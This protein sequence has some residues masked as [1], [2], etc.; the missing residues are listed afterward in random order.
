VRLAA[1]R[2]FTSNFKMEKQNGNLEGST[3]EPVN[4]GDEMTEAA[5]GATTDHPRV[6]FGS[7]E[8]RLSFRQWVV[9]GLILVA[10]FWSVPA[11]WKVVEKFQ[12]GPGY[13]IPYALSRD[14]WLYE[15]WIGKNIQPNKVIILGDSVVWG[16]YVD[17]QGSYGVFLTKK[18][19]RGQEFINGGVNGLFPLAMEGMVDHYLKLPKGQKIVVH[20]NLL[21]LTSPEADLSTKKEEHFNHA[22]LVPQFFPK[23]PCYRAD[24]NERL[25]ASLQNRVGFLGWTNHLQDAYFEQ[26]SILNWTLADNGAEP[27]AY[28]NA[29]R[30][31][32]GQITMSVPLAPN[33]DPLRGVGSDRHHPWS[34]T[35]VGTTRFDWVELRESMQWGAFRRVLEVLRGRGNEV[36]VVVGPLNEHLMDAENRI[37]YVAIRDGVGEWLSGAKVAHCVL[38][39]LPSLLYADASHPLTSGYELMAE[40][41]M[42]D[43]AFKKWL[44]RP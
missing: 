39:A 34:T 37:K 16:E 41:T 22:R 5:V 33:P 12:V 35:G 24:A 44:A 27:P 38:E 9:T 28:L 8:V 36:F 13:R 42:A 20:C 14:Y 4:R 17:P 7:N 19:D 32:L 31:P 43:E 29:W 23:I 6:P 10:I 30:N 21:W 3:E 15:R 40:R 26:K 11:I 18:S 2:L 25:V 1:G